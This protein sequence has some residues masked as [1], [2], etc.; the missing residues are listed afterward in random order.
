MWAL[1]IDQELTRYH[2]N[3]HRKC[4]WTDEWGFFFSVSGVK[5]RFS[6]AEYQCKWIIH[7]AM[8]STDI[9]L[10]YPQPYW[11]MSRMHVMRQHNTQSSDK[12]LK[13]TL[14]IKERQWRMAAWEYWLIMA[15]G[16]CSRQVYVSPAAICCDVQFS[17]T[18]RKQLLRARDTHQMPQ[19]SSGLFV[20]S[21][22]NIRLE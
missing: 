22:S 4:V 21:L 2:A 20:W 5:G 11:S 16:R 7:E 19:F 17:Q 9:L 3:A 12:H 1:L 8:C 10:K 6:R 13:R 14:T 15:D 18:N